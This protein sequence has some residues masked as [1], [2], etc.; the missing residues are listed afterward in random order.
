[1][2]TKK[3]TKE[4]SGWV[5]VNGR[6]VPVYDDTSIPGKN[7]DDKEKQIA[8]NKKQADMRN[9]KMTNSQKHWKAV[10]DFSVRANNIQSQE[11]AE[12]LQDDIYEYG[13]LNKIDT[14]K[15]IRDVDKSSL[16]D[17]MRRSY[18]TAQR[19]L[20]RSKRSNKKK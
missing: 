5:T 6:H 8:E 10:K 11:E 20:D 3:T 2:V 9:G 7:E 13:K 4:P 16:Q 15:S 12:K 18:D 17:S 1:M 19:Y 14:D